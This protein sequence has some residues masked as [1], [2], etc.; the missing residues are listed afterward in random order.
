MLPTFRYHPDPVATGSFEPSTEPCP[1]CGRQLGYI[2]N[3][4]IYAAEE[5]DPPCP[6]CIS[7]G[8]FARAHDASFTD[9]E[10]LEDLDLEVADEIL[11]RT[12]GFTGWQQERWL[13]H[14]DDGMAYHGP[15]GYSELGA[16]PDALADIRAELIELG[17]DTSG[18]LD[19]YLQA[20]SRDRPPSAY[21]FRCLTCGLESAYSDTT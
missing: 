10:P 2:Y 6:A 11:H 16:H 1:Y 18:W 19:E 8:S 7:D 5:P 13:T 17:G 4:P 20:L 3:G 9:E 14:H 15:V 21:L 12:P